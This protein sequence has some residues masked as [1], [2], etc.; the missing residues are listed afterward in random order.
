MI[1]AYSK[2]LD[3]L[4]TLEK[5]FLGIT[6][7]I[8]VIVMTY[9]VIL[10]YCFSAANSWSEEL[11][12]Y[13]FIYDVMIAAA[14]AT[15]RNSHLQVDFLINLLKPKVKYIFTIVATIAGIVFLGFLFNYSLT[16][17]QTAANNISAGLKISMSIPYACM[18]IGAVLMILTSL[19]VIFHNIL[20]I[21]GLDKKEVR[22]K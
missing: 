9:Q 22:G 6:V 21:R 2:F 19:E 15:R 4:E 1:K 3:K 14:I 7:A 13:L 11:A 8:M 18:P 12:R 5:Y 17:C 10:R 16:L 20:Q